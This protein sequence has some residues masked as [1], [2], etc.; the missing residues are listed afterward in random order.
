ML[1][2]SRLP[3]RTLGCEGADKLPVVAV[4]GPVRAPG[5][6][7]YGARSAGRVALHVEQLHL[8]LEHATHGADGAENLQD[9]LG[10]RFEDA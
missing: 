8:A 3:L 2:A 5:I 6:D 4:R 7:Y 9:G 10:L 1:S